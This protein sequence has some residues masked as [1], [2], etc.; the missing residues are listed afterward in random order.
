MQDLCAK[1]DIVDRILTTLC[2]FLHSDLI[3][4]CV[5]IGTYLPGRK[6]K[7][8]KIRGVL[9]IPGAPLKISVN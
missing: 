3:F 2:S 5:Q 1:K 6:H 7:D 9:R 8:F 4:M